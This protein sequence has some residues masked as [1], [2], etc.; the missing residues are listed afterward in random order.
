M[1]REILSVWFQKKPTDLEKFVE[2]EGFNPYTSKRNIVVDKYIHITN[3][4]GHIYLSILR[5]KSDKFKDI[6]QF[7]PDLALLVEIYYERGTIPSFFTDDDLKEKQQQT[8]DALI[9]E[10][11][12]NAHSY[13]P[14]QRVQGRGA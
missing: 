3:L 14:P 8:V 9:G 13:N 5:D 12:P 2:K 11:Y 4:A 10:Y 6:K 7:H 1:T